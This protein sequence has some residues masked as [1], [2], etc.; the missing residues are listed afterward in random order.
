ML[1]RPIIAFA[2]FALAAPTT[3]AQSNAAQTPPADKTL[4]FDVVSVN[5]NHTGSPGIVTRNLPDGYSVE[6]YPVRLILSTAFGI[7][8]DPVQVLL[9]QVQIPGRHSRHADFEDASLWNCPRTPDRKAHSED[10]K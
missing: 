2:A 1:V 7:R 10:H 3:P 8:A 4:A 6:N 5:P 9:G